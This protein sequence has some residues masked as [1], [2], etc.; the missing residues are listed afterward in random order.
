MP[1]IMFT[2][3]EVMEALPVDINGNRGSAK[4]WRMY[5]AMPGSAEAAKNVNE[6]VTYLLTSGV[7]YV[8]VYDLGYALRMAAIGFIRGNT[9]G[10]ESY[11]LEDSEPEQ[12]FY[13]FAERLLSSIETLSV[14]GR[15]SFPSAKLDILD[16]LL[17][18]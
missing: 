4:A 18:N 5:S 13:A 6:I 10:R 7:P 12:V 14:T 1:R 3:E 9:D 15:I 11:G 8:T 16:C 17:D 2:E